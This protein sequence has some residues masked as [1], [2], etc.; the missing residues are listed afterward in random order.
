VN[1]PEWLPPAQVVRVDDRGEVVVRVHRHPDPTAPVLLLLHGWTASADTQWLYAFPTLTERYSVVAVDHHGHGRGVRGR[2]PFD[3]SQVADDA[4]AVVRALG[5]ETVIA[6]GFS[7]GGPV[8]MHLWRG[9]PGLLSGMVL[10]ATALEWR[11]TTFDRIRWSIGVI[12]RPAFRAWWYPRVVHRALRSLSR[13]NPDLRQWSE[14]LTAEVMRND[15]YTLASA[16]RALSH[17]DARPWAASVSVPTAV[18]LTTKDRLVKP[19]K[20]RELASAIKATVFELP[21]D[22][23]CALANPGPFATTLRA[24][25]DDVA[26][27]GQPVARR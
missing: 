11:D 27:R 3:L 4:A 17:Y 25:V 5:F 8:G 7:M 1:I 24:A 19:R 6:V 12:V 18:V 16:G 2:E 9:H 22:H 20:Q 10:A 14:W 15:P 21:A 26:R 13:Q 23:L